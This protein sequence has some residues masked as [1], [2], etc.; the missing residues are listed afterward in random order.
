MKKGIR[1]KYNWFKLLQ[2]FILN[3]LTIINSGT[4]SESNSIE[5]FFQIIWIVFSFLIW[6]FLFLLF[7]KNIISQWN[8]IGIFFTIAIDSFSFSFIVYLINGYK[9]DIIFNNLEDILWLI[10]LPTILIY[11]F[12]FFIWI[13]LQKIVINMIDG[14]S[15]SPRKRSVE[16]N[17]T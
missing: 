16:N 10:F 4:S 14:E 12:I 9:I 1:K 5:F 11:I 2:F 17:K 7:D 13:H 15:D 3:I 8:K 6:H